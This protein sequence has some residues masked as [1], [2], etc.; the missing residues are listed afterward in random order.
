MGGI[1]IHV[2]ATTTHKT[3]RESLKV[4]T[5]GWVLHKGDDVMFCPH[6]G[7]TPKRYIKINYFF[8]MLENKINE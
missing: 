4:I 3:L 1:K 2:N 5:S 7:I 8:K 6:Y